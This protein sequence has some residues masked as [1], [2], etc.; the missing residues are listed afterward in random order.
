MSDQ[1]SMERF[2]KEECIRM[3]EW[4]THD[5]PKAAAVLDVLEEDASAERIIEAIQAVRDSSFYVLLPFL[6]MKISQTYHGSRALVRA[7]MNKYG[8]HLDLTATLDGFCTEVIKELK[9][10]QPV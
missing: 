3:M 2:R 8:N 10:F 9:N 7:F 6:F 5:L 1:S 4:F